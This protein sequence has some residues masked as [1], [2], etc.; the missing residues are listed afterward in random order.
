MKECDH[1]MVQWLRCN[2]KALSEEYGET[3]IHTMTSHLNENN[4][5]GP[6]LD[7][8]WTDSGVVTEI[9]RKMALNSSH[10]ISKP[11]LFDS[12]AASPSYCAIQK[13]F[14]RIFEDYANFNRDPFRPTSGTGYNSRSE[15]SASHSTWG[16]MFS[17]QKMRK[18]RQ[19]TLKAVSQVS[20]KLSK[21]VDSTAYSECDLD[22]GM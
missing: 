17:V 4:F 13:A 3:A 9:F 19:D 6:L 11:R 16:T 20:V 1:P 10:R 2:F 14:L 5:S 12:K 7:S 22:W 21:S 15:R 18:I 8:K